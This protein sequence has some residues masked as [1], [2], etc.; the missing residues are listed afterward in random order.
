MTDP[1]PFRELVCPLLQTFVMAHCAG[2]SDALK[3]VPLVTG[4]A[5]AERLW[6]MELIRVPF[7][8]EERKRRSYMLLDKQN[9]MEKE[10]NCCRRGERDI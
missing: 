2:P 3:Y 7:L 8:G 4:L 10:G 1:Q 9:N 6:R 5:A